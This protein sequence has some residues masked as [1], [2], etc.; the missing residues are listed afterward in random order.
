MDKPRFIVLDGIDGC[1]KSSQAAALVQALEQRRGKPALHLR[2]PGSTPLGEALREIL[3]GRNFEPVTEVEALLVCAARKQMLERC[4]K[5]ALEEG[6]DVVCER[7]HSSTFAYQ[8][9]AGGLGMDRVG[10]LLEEWAGSPKPDRIVILEID[11]KRA[12]A[13]RGA[14]SDRIEDRGIEFQA[15]VAEGFAVYAELEDRAVL[16]DGDASLDC[17]AKAVLTEVLRAD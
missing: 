11:P 9:W 12:F 3:L 2:E 10:R 8:G 4:V 17:V 13:R 5:P 16:V 15:R 7:F 6:R 1:G 14:D